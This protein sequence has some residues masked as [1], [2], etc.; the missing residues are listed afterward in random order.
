[1]KTDFI[2]TVLAEEFGLIGGLALLAAF[3]IVLIYSLI[4]GIGTR[5]QFGRLLAGGLAITLFLYVFINI[6]MVM[7]MLPVVGVPLPMVSYGGSAMMTWLIAFGLILS[8][9]THRHMTL[10]PRGSGLA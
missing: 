10:A 9:A 3:G 2:F 5:N 8:V 6:G 1:M 7:G 4:I